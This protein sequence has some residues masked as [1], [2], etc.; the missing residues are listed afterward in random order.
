MVSPQDI[1]NNID[2]FRQ[3]FAGYE[4]Y[5]TV[6]GGTACWLLMEE[7]GKTGRATKDIDMILIFEDGG[8]EFGKLFWKFIED[9]GYSYGK[10]DDDCH[11][12]RFYNP[13][14]GFPAQIELFSRRADFSLDA[15]IIPVHITDDISSLSAIALDEDFYRFMKAGRRVVG[16]ISVLDVPYIIPFK[17]YAWLNN[18]AD[19]EAGKVVN[20]DNVSKHKKDVFR[21]LP[22]LNPDDRI[23]VE[24]SVKTAVDAFFD[25]MLEEE[26][27]DALLYGRKKEEA[28]GILRAIYVV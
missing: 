16:G 10:K 8:E 27:S 3:A 18:K 2:S 4:D 6:I 25:A 23:K 5:Y 14:S 1:R 11:Y 12:Y 28:I 17:M 24:G 22:L 13:L 9:G 21:L 19:K 15:T 7:A 26:I 20:D